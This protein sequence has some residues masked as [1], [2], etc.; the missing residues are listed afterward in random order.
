[1]V[2]MAARVAR[3]IEETP[4][5]LMLRDSK[6]FR[7]P[8]QGAFTPERHPTEAVVQGAATPPRADYEEAVRINPRNED[9]KKSLDALG[10]SR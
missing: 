8:R 3:I 1:M 6:S 10:G 2:A 9:A 5:K 4:R 7:P